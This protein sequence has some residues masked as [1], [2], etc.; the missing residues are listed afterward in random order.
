LAEFKNEYLIQGG[1]VN[2]Q[3]YIQ[4]YLIR[5]DNEGN[6]IWEKRYS[7]VNTDQTSRCMRILDDNTILIAGT[8]NNG[9]TYPNPFPW[10]RSHIMAVD[11]NGIIKWE[12]QSPLN[13]GLVTDMKKMPDGDWLFLQKKYI[14]TFG[15]D[16][17]LGEMHLVRSDSNFNV[18]WRKLLS[19]TPWN[20]GLTNEMLPT[21]DGHWIISEHVAIYGP[22]FEWIDPGKK[23]GCLTKVSSEGEIF[24]QTCDTARWEEPILPY[25][26]EEFVIDHVVL[27]SGSSILVGSVNR[28]QAPVRSYGWMFKVDANGCMYAPCSVPV[29][30]PEA[31]G[32]ALSVYPNPAS[33][34]FTVRLPELSR[35]AVLE[36]YDALGRLVVQLPVSPGQEVVSVSAVGW[37]AG[38]YA[39]RLVQQGRVLGAHRVMVK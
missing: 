29:E 4:D 33:E 22:E 23:G 7:P 37:H 15:L 1:L 11:S 10:T 30:A 12:W 34:H 13:Y 24:W 14:M 3:N 36:T 25:F 9:S 6:V 18:K 39:I 5:L 20:K 17:V 21:P 35:S 8:V 2:I 32:I 26:T 28:Y 31:P 16:S 19:P 38:L 27:P